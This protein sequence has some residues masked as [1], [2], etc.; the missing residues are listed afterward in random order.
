MILFVS[1]DIYTIDVQ[2][3]KVKQLYHSRRFH[4]ISLISWIENGRNVKIFEK[5]NRL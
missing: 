1:D 4:E 3:E 5:S 2:F